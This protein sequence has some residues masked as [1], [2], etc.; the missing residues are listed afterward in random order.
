MTRKI[1]ALGLALIATLAI[2]SVA[3]SAAQ[4]A[5]GELHSE[6]AAGKTTAILTA[7][8][9]GLG[10]HKFTIKGYSLD[11]QSAIAEGKVQKTTTD[12]TITP[13]YTNCKYSNGSVPKFKMNGCK[14]TFTGVA[15]FTANVDI[16][17][18]TAGKSIEIVESFCTVTIPEQKELSHVVF[19][20]TAGP[21]EDI[22]VST[23]ISGITYIGDGAC[24]E[25]QGH[26]AD[27]TLAGTTTVR[28]YEDE[29]L[30]ALV[31]HEGHCYQPFKE[32]AQV[33]LFS[34]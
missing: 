13:Q 34:T 24:G 19:T 32:G 23:T 6:V 26:H 10:A 7:Q 28:A 30:N 5:P 11:C 22:H 29:G 17:G 27:G 21:K 1:K 12:A 8:N 3:V 16:V 18:C 20:N 15:N 33:N 9:L 14:Y 2:G 4:A 31:T 25:S